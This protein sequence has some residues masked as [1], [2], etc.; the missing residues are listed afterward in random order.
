MKNASKVLRHHKSYQFQ[1]LDEIG[2]T[3]QTK[4]PAWLPGQTRLKAG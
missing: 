1:V 2:T 4:D 3:S